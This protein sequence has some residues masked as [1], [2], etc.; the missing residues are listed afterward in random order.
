VAPVTSELVEAAYVEPSHNIP[1]YIPLF[2]IDKDQRDL[3]AYDR[4]QRG[5]IGLEG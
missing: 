2:L 4:E 5:C 1:D 3:V